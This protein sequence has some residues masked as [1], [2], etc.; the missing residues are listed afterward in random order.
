M[1]GAVSVVD[2]DRSR[3]SQLVA[4]SNGGFVDSAWPQPQQTMLF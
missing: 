1:Y 2:V 4:S 3:L